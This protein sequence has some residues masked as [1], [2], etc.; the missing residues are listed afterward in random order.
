V[1]DRLSASI[2]MTPRWS[3]G[4]CIDEWQRHE[5]VGIGVTLAGLEAFG[6]RRGIGAVR[7]SGLAVT[8]YQQIAALHIADADRF[9]PSLAT[10]LAQLDIAAELGAHCVYLTTGPRGDL[11]WDHAGQLVVDQLQSLLPHFRDRNLRPALEPLHPLRQDLCFLNM[12]DDTVDLL[13]RI[14]DAQV[15]YV[16]DT[17]HLWWQRRALDLA[18]TSASRVA[19]VQLS[20]HKQITMRTLDRAMLGQGIAPIDQFVRAFEQGGYRGLYDL[21]IISDDN[22]AKGYDVALAEAVASALRLWDGLSLHAR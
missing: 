8:S 10:T 21:E 4:R 9:A 5:L 2:T 11:G 22:E 13:D 3:L 18:L 6:V 1:K 17:W 12:V 20:D 19:S 16:F 7:T 15:G 14:G